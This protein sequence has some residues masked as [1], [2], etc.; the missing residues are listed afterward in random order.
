MKNV[1]DFSKFKLNSNSIKK[2]IGGIDPNGHQN[3]NV[4]F[5]EE[6]HDPNDPDWAG[7]GSS[8]TSSSTSYSTVV[9]DNIT[10]IISPNTSN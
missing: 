5:D 8:T 4:L 9:N 1:I 10:P 6:F 7:P 2:I 3:N